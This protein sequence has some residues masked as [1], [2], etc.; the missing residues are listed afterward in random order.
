M[1]IPRL[2]A[3]IVAVT[4][5]HADMT[6][7]LCEVLAAATAEKVIEFGTT[8]MVTAAADQIINAEDFF[9]ELRGMDVFGQCMALRH[10]RH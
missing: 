10:P 7:S 4:A 6:A 3:E 1:G 8:A 2:R 5:A 9:D